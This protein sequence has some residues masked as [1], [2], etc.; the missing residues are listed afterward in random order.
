MIRK[1]LITLFFLVDI[2]LAT[3]CNPVPISPTS[4]ANIPNPASINCEQQGN[5]LEIVTAADGSQK[6][7]CIFPDGSS[8]DEWAYFRG[9]CGP[10]GQSDSPSASTE[11]STA[12]QDIDSPN[13]SLTPPPHTATVTIPAQVAINESLDYCFVYPEGFTLLINDSQVEVV[14]PHSGLGGLVAGLVWIDVTDAQGST[15]QEIADEVV[16]AF[17][18]SPPRSTV[19]LGG[20]EALVLDGMPGQD[21]IRKVYIVHNGLLYTLN[22][23]PYQSDN[24]T[25]NAQMETLFASVTSSWVWISSGWPCPATE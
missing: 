17:G 19:M 13:I 15:A 20:E 18:G 8:C 14:G 6:G 22:F 24:D 11:V 12:T 16:N 10:T 2:A 23:S 4:Q 9:E 3:S 5:K 1:T 7:L 21:A 25:A